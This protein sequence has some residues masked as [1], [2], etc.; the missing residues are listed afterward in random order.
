LAPEQVAA[1]RTRVLAALAAAGEAGLTQ[2]EVSAGVFTRNRTRAQLTALLDQLGGEDL[3]VSKCQKEPGVKRP[4][5][6]WR[7]IDTG[8]NSFAPGDMAGAPP[9]GEGWIPWSDAL[10]LAEASVASSWALRMGKR[11]RARER[12]RNK[13]R[14]PNRKTLSDQ[15][16]GARFVA[17]RSLAE[18]QRSGIIERAGDWCR[19]GR[20]PLRPPSAWMERVYLRLGEEHPTLT[21]RY[22][23]KGD[24]PV[25][26]PLPRA[27]TPTPR[28]APVPVHQLRITLRD[29][30]PRIWRRVQVPSDILLVR[31]HE[32]LQAAMGWGD[33]HLHSFGGHYSGSGYAEA[34][35]WTTTLARFAPAAGDG[36]SYEYDFGDFWEHL[37]VVEK[38]IPAGRRPRYPVCIAGR[39]A[40]P[41]EDCGGPPGYLALVRQTKNRRGD[42]Y[43]WYR[44]IYERSFKAEAFDLEEINEELAEL[45]ER[46][47]S[48]RDPER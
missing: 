43:Y 30:E 45:A 37:V 28:Q 16:R 9:E 25:R 32:V 31:L 47:E 5:V 34:Y 46:R 12:K 3:V 19:L 41:P 1:D 11:I 48:V 44:D 7:L 4:I 17:R 18:A 21:G 23:P 15:Q 42:R 22:V 40:C 8:A 36:F 14:Y 2:T 26:R 10:A 20:D 38:V 29:I 27:K 13:T 6:R 24:G 33:M 39:R 35:E